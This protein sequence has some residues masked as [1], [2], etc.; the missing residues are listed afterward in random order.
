MQHETDLTAFEVRMN[1][2]RLLF[3]TT[4]FLASFLLFLV[5][6]IAAR[7]LLPILGGS[8]AVWITCLV[9]FQTALLL[10]YLYA[11][12]L[13]RRPR[14]TF[15]AI[16]LAVAIG[17]PAAWITANLDFVQGS[18][19]PIWT[20]FRLLGVNIGLP[21]IVLSATSPLLQVWW[22]QLE[23]GEIP[24]RLYALSNVASLL[25]LGLYPTIVEPHL[26]LHTQRLVWSIG[27]AAFVIL[28]GWLARIHR[29]VLPSPV[30]TSNDDPGSTPT[31]LSHKLLWFFLPLGAAMQLCAVTA[32]L[33][34]NVAAIPLLWI[35]PLGVYL[36]T[37]IVAFQFQVTLPWGIIARVMVVMLGA[38]A[39]T[40]SKVN[41]TWPLWLSITFFL[42]EL[43]FACIFCHSAATGL[44]PQRASEATVFYLLF[45]AGGAAG[46]FLIGIAAPLVFNLNLDL[47]LTFLITA[48]LALAVNWRGIWSQRLL[49]IVASAGML[50]VTFMVRRALTHDATVTVRN[51]YASLRVTQDLF[52][53]P[54]TTVRTLMNGSIQ[55]GTQI[56]GTDELR[57]TPTTYYAR[58]SGVG[59]AIRFCCGDGPQSR[60]RS[61]GVIGLGAGTIAAYGQPGDHIRFYDINPAVQ[62]IARNV[63]T[64]IR[65]SQAQ[66]DIIEGDAR[67]SLARE[68]PQHFDVLVVDA[69]SG[70]AIPIHL[71]TREALD[72]YRRHLAPGGILAFHI[73]NRHVDLEPPI[74]L[75]AAS[76]HMEAR[77]VNSLGKEE[78]GAY[79]STWMLVTDNADFFLQPELVAHAFDPDTKPGLRLWTDDY[80]ALLPVLRW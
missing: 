12:W 9:F 68:Q 22:T 67:T 44:R 36:I 37:I 11:H 16:S 34:A 5:E 71:L 60:P 55:H 31:P 69:F 42:I 14:R 46:S 26:A 57:R 73:S 49:W 8:A 40:L 52:S 20:V 61:I 47:P 6:P 79:S 27:F 2:Q 35:L 17:S 48:L 24:Y 65:D 30:V 39:Y 56:F 62:P 7:Q 41:S 25:A 21:F 80:S 50:V 19:H 13:T 53:Y 78:P 45:A 76:A 66:I 18:A 3:A 59:L 72:L 15:Y 58:D 23:H 43:F 77:H 32:Y 54:G 75:L 4:I 38:L 29:R 70:D 64:Y 33:T 28:A 51:F 74:A 1:G 10:G 63:F